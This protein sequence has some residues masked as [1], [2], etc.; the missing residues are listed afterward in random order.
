MNQ[1]ELG[2][3]R[4]GTDQYLDEIRTELVQIRIESAQSQSQSGSHEKL[5]G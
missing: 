3:T 5:G 1:G 4:R 2:R